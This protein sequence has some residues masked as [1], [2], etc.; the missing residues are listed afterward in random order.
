[1]SI[2]KHRSTAIIV[3]FIIIPFGFYTKIYSGAGHEWVNNKLGG[4][5]YEIFW[6]LLFYFLLPKSKPIF[7]VLWVFIITV[8]LEFVQL[9]N[10]SF[11]E[12]IRSNFIGKTLIGSTFSWSDFPYYIAGSLLG[13]F[14]INTIHKTRFNRK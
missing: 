5:F 7:I 12:I 14:I 2:R 13:Y 8:L 4:V 6:C 9:L 10:Y 3:L 1:M 11:L